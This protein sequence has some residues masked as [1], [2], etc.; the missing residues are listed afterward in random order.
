MMKKKK[1]ISLMYFLGGGWLKENFIVKHTKMIVLIFFLLFLYI[2]IRYLCLIKL[3]EIDKLQNQLK[4]L[5]YEKTQTSAELDGYTRPSQIEESVKKQGL[6][7]Q[8]ATTPPYK[9]K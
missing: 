1:K 2:S 4:E 6:D 7:I 3:R 8:R 9:L 5:K